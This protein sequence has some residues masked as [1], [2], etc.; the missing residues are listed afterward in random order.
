MKVISAEAIELKAPNWNSEATNATRPTL[1]I[2][3]HF[4]KFVDFICVTY[5]KFILMQ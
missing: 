3:S 1:V 2:D 4:K 5:F